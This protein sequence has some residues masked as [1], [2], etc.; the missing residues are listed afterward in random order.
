M[1]CSHRMFALLA[2]ILPAAA[3]AGVTPV[4]AAVSP[5]VDDRASLPATPPTTPTHLT[6]GFPL[7]AVITMTAAVVIL[8]AFTALIAS[9]A[10]RTRRPHARIP[11]R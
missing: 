2:L 9:A 1:S 6:G 4:A 5:P 11:S 7:W 8:I 10:R 3:P